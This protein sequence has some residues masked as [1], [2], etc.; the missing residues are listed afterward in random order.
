MATTKLHFDYPILKQK[1]ILIHG[2]FSLSDTQ[3]L[4]QEQRFVN[5]LVGHIWSWEWGEKA[6]RGMCSSNSFTWKAL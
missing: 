4:V 6:E 3:I 5:P 1:Y 2:R